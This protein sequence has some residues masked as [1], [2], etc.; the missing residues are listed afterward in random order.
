MA[1]LRGR[2][3]AQA[4]LS[5][6]LWKFSSQRW[7]WR[8]RD[9]Q[10]TDCGD[11]GTPSPTA[12][13]PGPK[14]RQAKSIEFRSAPPGLQPLLHAF[15]NEPWD[16]GDLGSVARPPNPSHHSVGA[17]PGTL[18]C[19]DV[20]MDLADACLVQ[21]THELRTGAICDGR[22]PGLRSPR[23]SRSWGRGVHPARRDRGGHG[24]SKTGRARG[25]RWPS[26]CRRASSG[27]PRVGSGGARGADSRRIEVERSGFAGSSNGCLR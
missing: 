19:A 18:R 25:A 22:S 2:R 5:N 12:A 4:A 17:R 7:S 23:G 11:V 1:T 21:M 26:R 20:P 27:A 9:A 16:L 10:A 3:F 14:N 13:E 24:S 6:A 8:L 15:A